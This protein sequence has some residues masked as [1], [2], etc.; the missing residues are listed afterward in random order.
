MNIAIIKAGG[1][2]SRMGAGV[3]KQFITVGDKP[4]IV[5]TL[6]VFQSHPSIDQIVVVCVKGWEDILGSYAQ[7]FGITKLVKIVEGGESSLKSIRNGV[8]AIRNDYQ[9]DDMVLIHDANRPLV[10][11]E[12]ITDVLVESGLHGM[13]VA[14]IPCT[15]EIMVSDNAS[16]AREFADRKRLFRI[17]TP[18]AYRLETLLNIFDTATEE[19]LT[20]IGATNVLAINMGYEVKFANGSETNIRLTNQEDIARFEALLKVAG[21]AS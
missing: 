21:K 3:P 4:I 1:V 17:Q 18:D 11:H 10:S 16:S 6:E 15:D 12:I 5:Y 19:Q 13:A 8:F 2:G 20:T 9:K 14:A 7:K